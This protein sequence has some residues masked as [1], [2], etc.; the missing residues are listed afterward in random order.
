MA[1]ISTA[2][3]KLWCIISLTKLMSSQ[4]RAGM[5]PLL[6]CRV[7]QGEH[8]KSEFKMLRFERL[9]NSLKYD[10]WPEQL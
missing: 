10:S 4:L 2:V 3:D 1:S 6:T 7:S 8:F 5:R 9:A